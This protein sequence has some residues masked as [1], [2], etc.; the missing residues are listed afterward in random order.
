VTRPVVANASPLI[1]LA[2]INRLPILRDLWGEIILPEAVYREVVI[3]GAGRTGSTPVAQAC[4]DWMRIMAAQ[5]RQEV[6][7]L[8]AVLDE[9]E[10]EVIVLGQELHAG[11]LLLDNREPRVFARGLDLPVMGTL[12][13]LLAGWRRGLVKEP[14]H[15]AQRLRHVGFWLDDKLLELLRAEVFASPRQPPDG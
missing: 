13:V 4:G 12:G 5:D 6:S 15:D 3:D 10:A 11:L 8:R 14:L 1:G 9:G 7:A 2:A